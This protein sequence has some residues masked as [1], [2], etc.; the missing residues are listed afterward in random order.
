MNRSTYFDY[1]EEKLN[2]LAYR[3]DARGRLNI[4]DL[5]LHSENFYMDFIN[6]LYGWKLENLNSLNQNVE[7]IDLIDH[8]NKI[9]VQV[10]ATASKQK[11]E[12]S[13]N[14]DI[15]SKYNSYKFLF[16]S[17]SKGT[18]SLRDKKFNNPY[19]IVFNP[20][21]DIY[22][23]LSILKK[24]S[25]LRIDR[26]REVFDFIKSELGNSVD[27][28]KLDS[29][30]ANI[31]N[32]LAKENLSNIVEKSNI[33]EFQI[34]RKIEYN[35]LDITNDIIED[36]KIY[37]GHLQKKYNVFNEQGSNTSIAVLN[38]IRKQYINLISKKDYKNNDILFLEIIDQVK[39]K[40]VN[41]KNYIDLS[42]E[43]LDLCVGILVVD[44]FIRCKIFK[45]PEGYSYVNTR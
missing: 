26:Q 8:S 6:L 41:S 1:I 20:R 22:D 21:E 10:S 30:L 17:I 15:I 5:N 44:A 38:S 43:Q 36:Y 11:I 9:V 7:G 12:K 37:H 14:K 31:I 16:V 2:I 4:L 3:I 33:N 40:V 45:N 24:I 19:K 28:H 32:I 29:D 34:T 18:D 27:M 35:K 23:I 25:T 39:D 42:F 13:L